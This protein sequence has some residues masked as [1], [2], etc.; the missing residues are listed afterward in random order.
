[1]AIRD[2]RRRKRRATAPAAKSRRETNR[3]AKKLR[4][5]GTQILPACF[6]SRIGASLQ[7]RPL[8]SETPKLW[9]KMTETKNPLSNLTPAQAIDLR[10]TLRDIKA[11]RWVLSPIEPSHLEQ[12]IAMGL[13]EMR[14]DD[15]ILTNSGVDAIQ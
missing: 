8:L 11:K 1:L 14:H 2:R 6:H 9:Q 10:W 5:K 3:S 12:L 4:S 7:E 13:V 15:P